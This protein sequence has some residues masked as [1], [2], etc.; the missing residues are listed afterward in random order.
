[1]GKGSSSAPSSDPRIGEASLLS[2]QTGRDYLDWMRTQAGITNQWAAQDRQRYRAVFQPLQDEFIATAQ[3]WDS[4]DRQSQRAAEARA[5]VLRDAGLAR[6][7]SDR[8]LAAQGVRPDAGRARGI[9]RALDLETALAAAGAE[10]MARGR[11]RTEAMNLRGNAIN[12]GSGLAVNPLSSI[13]VSNQGMAS[14]TQGALQGYA[15]QASMLGQQDRMRLQAWQHN[16]NASAAMFGAL[17]NLTGL[18]L[19][20]ERAKTDKRPAR[21]VLDAVK[22]M[23]VDRWRY[24]PGRG[25]EGEHIGPYAQDFAR[26]TGLGDGRRIGVIDALGVTLGAV[27][28]LAGQVDRIAE[29]VS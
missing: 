17:G 12:L 14:G 13:Q 27:K 6:Q 7:R 10:N 28:E 2:A 19:S 5:G 29:R 9:G 21:G 22:G 15:N 25:D 20:D 4:P 3:A 24:K 23:R 16:Q 11:T 26:R 18:F 8:R 1:M